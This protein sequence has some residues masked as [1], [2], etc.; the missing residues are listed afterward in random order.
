MNTLHLKYAVEVEKTG[1][2]SK[3]AENLYMNQP[4]LSKT[5]R[6]LEDSLGI[7]IFK[8]TTKGVIPTKKGA[9]FLG[10]AKNILAQ[11]EEMESIYKPNSGD[12][13]SFDIAVP[14]SSYISYAFTEF[15]KTL[16]PDAAMS[17]NYRET[18]S[19]STITNVASGDYNM[20]IVRY[21]KMYEHYF[22]GMIREKGLKCEPVMDFVYLALMSKEHPLASKSSVD[23]SELSKYTEIT[24]GDLTIPSLP[25]AK[26]PGVSV[27]GTA[28]R[29]IAV[30]ER[31]SQFEL[32]MRIKTTY[33]WVSPM[34]TS[35]LELFSLTERP[36]PLSEN[37]QRDI[38]IYRDGYRMTDEDKMFLAKLRE[39]V[40]EVKRASSI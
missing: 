7:V 6:E 39:S 12:K 16:D 40:A 14:R 20:G 29:Q 4:H 33:M 3:A 37:N 32:L 13:I 9:E 38:L 24:H 19:V 5:I 11:L 17:I 15:V 25:L 30:Y 22:M 18:N 8:R 31:G 35:L 27:S 21:P 1:S 34:P 36:C 10:Y 23:Y 2:I 26:N 28:R